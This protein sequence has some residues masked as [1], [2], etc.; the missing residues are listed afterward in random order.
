MSVGICSVV[1]FTNDLI[2]IPLLYLSQLVIKVIM[3]VADN[4]G[5]P[6]SFKWHRFTIRSENRIAFE[7]KVIACILNENLWAIKQ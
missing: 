5:S 6:L 3:F 1:R 4:R 7:P 2:K